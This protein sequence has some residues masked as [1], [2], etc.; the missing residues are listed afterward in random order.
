MIE[1]IK[2]Y[3]KTAAGIAVAII[4]SAIS[5]FSGLGID[6]RGQICGAPEVSETELP[7]TGE[8]T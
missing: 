3:K 4:V 2:A 5:M 7:G 8:V 6:L 1:E